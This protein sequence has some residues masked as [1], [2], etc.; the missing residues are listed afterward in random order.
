[1]GNHDHAKGR[2]TS[3][4]FGDTFNRGINKGK[5]HNIVLSACGTWGYYDIPAKK[6]RMV[7]LNT[8]DEGY[9]GMSR[10]QLQFLADTFLAAP[11]GWH[12]AVMQHIQVPHILGCWRRFLEPSSMNREMITRATGSRR[13]SSTTSRSRTTGIS[14]RSS[15]RRAATGATARTYGSL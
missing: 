9:G 10:E 15:T 14:W 6:F 11:E 8:S 13:R 5:G 1:M 12:V 2:Y 4:Q 7:F 3:Q